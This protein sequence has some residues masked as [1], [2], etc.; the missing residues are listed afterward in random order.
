MRKA[1]ILSFL[2]FA[3]TINIVAQ[4]LSGYW[5]V[6][7]N[8][9]G[10][11]YSYLKINVLE[12]NQLEG[13]YTDGNE[14]VKLVG[15]VYE[16][17]TIMLAEIDSENHR[18]TYNGAINADNTITGFYN[19]DNGNSNTFAWS[20]SCNEDGIA[21]D[22]SN[23]NC[24]ERT[25]S[26]RTETRM[27]KKQMQIAE[28]SYVTGTK[29]R[30]ENLPIAETVTDI[31]E[32]AIIV[33]SIDADTIITYKT[34]EVEVPEEVVVVENGAI[35]KKYKSNKSQVAA[36]IVT[37]STET[38]RSTKVVKVSKESATT[39]VTC[40][41][42]VATTQISQNKPTAYSNVENEKPLWGSCDAG[43]SNP[44]QHLSQMT[45]GTT[46]TEN[47]RTYHVVGKGETMTAICKK[48]GIN[49]GDLAV[50]NNKSCERINIGEKLLIK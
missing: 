35:E 45:E 31:P 2:T 44:S 42:T 40:K 22:G 12:A 30:D 34:V 5:R 25:Q 41:P 20:K 23:N 24:I 15:N 13:E 18:R 8:A 9:D 19:D 38:Q 11:L 21:I 17:Q 46:L 43:A 7:D 6:T 49:L 50:K 48:Y 32:N 1:I 36:N 33:G 29:T 28:K 37:N 27:V 16:D 47:G 10:K 39:K 4:S 3:V 26:K 14:T